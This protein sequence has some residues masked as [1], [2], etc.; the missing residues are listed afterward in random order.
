M[1][2]KRNENSIIIIKKKQKTI[3]VKSP[4]TKLETW[5]PDKF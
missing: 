4:L 5:Q 1:E 3:L 2:I